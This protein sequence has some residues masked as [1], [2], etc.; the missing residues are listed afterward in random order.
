MRR[1]SILLIILLLIVA[2]IIASHGGVV[3]LLFLLAVVTDTITGSDSPLTNPCEH[4]IMGQFSSPDRRRT[5]V[6]VLTNCGATTPFVSSILIKS[7]EEDFKIKR[8]N[9]FFVVK[10][11]NDIEVIWDGNS[12]LT[13]VY[14]RPSL[15]YSD[16]I[17]RQE[18]MWQGLH[19]SYQEK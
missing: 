19:I 13:V 15:T 16:K 9:N 12:A 11:Q 2:A 17:Y 1:V 10:G 8:N 3:T 4:E 14:E 18:K 5:A 6:V 7:A